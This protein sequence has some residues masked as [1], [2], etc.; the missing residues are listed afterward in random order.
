MPSVTRHFGQRLMS[1][2]PGDTHKNHQQFT[3]RQMNNNS[4]ISSAQR[5]RRLVLKVGQQT[6]N[7]NSEAVLAQDYTP[8][9]IVK[10]AG[11]IS[12]GDM[13]SNANFFTDSIEPPSAAVR[14]INSKTQIAGAINAFY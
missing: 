1:A 10:G 5:N 12:G 7:I 14:S 9:K 4:R 13:N 6:G 8:N 3:N 11:E 2:K